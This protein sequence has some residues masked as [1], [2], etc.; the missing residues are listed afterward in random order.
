MSTTSDITKAS[1]S[2]EKAEAK[3]ARVQ[4]RRDA[5]VA[6]ATKKA[7]EKYDLKVVDATKAIDAARV[8]LQELAANA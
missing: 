7:E 3:F 8:K 1:K 2:L 6:K 5:A 4:S